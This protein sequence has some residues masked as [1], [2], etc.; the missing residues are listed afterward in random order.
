MIEVMDEPDEL[1]DLVDASDQPIGTIVRQE[2]LSLEA[3]GRG[4]ARGVGVF[5]VN[6]RGKLW[7]PTRQEHK[8]I[9]PGGLDFSVG[10][11]VGQGESYRNAA[12]RGLDEELNITPV[13]DRLTEIGTVPPFTGLPY[14]HTLF[15]YPSDEVPA[16]N[17]ADFS[18][19]EWLSPGTLANRLAQGAPA[20]EVL[21][22]SLQ[23]LMRQTDEG[24]NA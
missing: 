6:S 13:A 7:I 2:V 20:K 22:P 18:G 4:F 1:L 16:F 21:L 14:F 10:E 15:T 11:H 19:F 24:E 8:A 5:V 9:A 3:S 12:L 17:Q 23:L